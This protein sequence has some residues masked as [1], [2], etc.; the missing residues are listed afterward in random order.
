MIKLF[1]S[2]SLLLVLTSCSA[3]L[4]APSI[5]SNAIETMISSNQDITPRTKGSTLE[6]TPRTKGSTYIRGLIALSGNMPHD[7]EVEFR[8]QNVFIKTQRIQTNSAGDFEIQD[9]EITP[10]EPLFIEA[11]AIDYPRI[12]LMGEVA[13]KSL[14]ETLHL[15]LSIATTSAVYL[16]RYLDLPSETPGSLLQMPEVL[17]PVNEMMRTYFLSQIT[18]E[19]SEAMEDMPEMKNSLEKARM[20]WEKL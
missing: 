3:S 20:L 18:Q 17:S 10:G 2:L 12:I 16:S 4:Q 19:T 15:E 5:Q 9:L 14:P 6:V 11:R 13:L 8:Q 1:I 7:F